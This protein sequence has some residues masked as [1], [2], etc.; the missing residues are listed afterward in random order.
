MDLFE[1][2]GKQFFRQAGIPVPESQL[3][4]SPACP[5]PMPFPYVLKAQ[6]MT[7]GRGKLG[8]IQVCRNEEEFHTNAASILGMTMKGHPV[9]GL[10]AEE[11]VRP[12][13]ELY[14]AMT[15]Q[16]VKTPTLIASAMGGMEIERVAQEHPEE[17]V[18]MEVD[19]FLGLKDYQ[20]RALAS[21]LSITD[22][23][24]LY[25]LLE[26]LQ[27][28]FF[29]YE[30]L[31]VEINPLGVVDGRLVA[32][33]SKIV[34]D[35][36]ARFRHEALFCSLEEKRE[37]LGCPVSRGDGTTITYVPLEGDIGLISDG[38]GTGMFALDLLN[39]AGGSVA[40]FCE[41]GGTTSAEVMYKAMEY[42]CQNQNLKS[43][44]VV[45][46]GGF[47]RMDDMA[48]GITQYLNDHPSHIPVFTR[49]CGTMEEV[50]F[51]IMNDAGLF[52]CQDLMVAVQKA[53]AAG[54]G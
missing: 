21:K 9:H 51:K 6:V 41:L 33:D 36:H 50:G 52:T 7:G 40:S 28:I 25:Q 43:I 14:L 30:A 23:S 27:H 19:P 42:T 32:M 24:G 45:L 34:L 4:S 29:T 2:E 5:P 10:L 44:L 49:M 12:E 18:R 13:R 20:R 11:M 35:D 53:V 22:T 1:Y 46:I 38:A 48:N 47:N 39:R 15:L 37:G 26:R 3:V 31:L 17:L 8:G 54:E 16:G